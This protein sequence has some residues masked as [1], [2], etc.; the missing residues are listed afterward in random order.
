MQRPD[1]TTVA[2]SRVNYAR[3]AACG[4]FRDSA[5]TILGRLLDCYEAKPEI[6]GTHPKSNYQCQDRD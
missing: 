1:F 4:D 2:V 3:M 6:S 5:D